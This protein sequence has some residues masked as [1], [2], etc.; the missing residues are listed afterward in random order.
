MTT[1]TR[2]PAC[3]A[4][5]PP[6]PVRR[7]DNIRDGAAGGQRG[8][9]ST[10]HASHDDDVR[11]VV[12]AVP[13]RRF[14]RKPAGVHRAAPSGTSCSCMLRHCVAGSAR[15]ASYSEH[16]R[17][18]NG[19][20]LCISRHAYVNVTCSRLAYAGHLHVS[21]QIRGCGMARPWTRVIM[22]A[23]LR[24]HLASERLGVLINSVDNNH[25]TTNMRATLGALAS[26]RP[27]SEAICRL[28]YHSLPTARETASLT[29]PTAINLA[30]G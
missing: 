21:L 16:T 18:P 3:S 14:H 19:H 8:A 13:A 6:P 30:L 25:F 5:P 4:A 7:S 17:S 23:M 15:S 28:R 24:S 9:I 22:L 20:I 26:A 2:L 11:D 12:A 1:L 29:T 27:P 10:A